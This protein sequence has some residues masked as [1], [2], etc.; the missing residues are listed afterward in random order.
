MIFNIIVTYQSKY[1][2]KDANS[3]VI[4]LIIIWHPITMMIIGRLV[5]L[6]HEND[7]DDDDGD[8]NHSRNGHV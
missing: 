7:N 3:L 2:K 8:E 6:A 1:Q 4:V 5:I